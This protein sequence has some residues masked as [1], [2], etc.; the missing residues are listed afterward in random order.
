L[1]G[2]AVERVLEETGVELPDH[3]VVSSPH[4]RVARTVAHGFSAERVASAA[5]QAE[6]GYTGA[7]DLG[8][9]LADALDRAAPGETV[10][11]VAASDGCDTA[12]LEV[13]DAID[14]I[15][16]SAGVR[17]Q[18]A[19]GREV[20]YADYLTWRGI[21]ERESPRRPDPAAPAGPA[22][23]R[24]EGWKFRFA[25]SRC[26]ECQTMH[27]PPQRTCVECGAIDRMC[28]E[29]LADR[30]GT[31][32]TYSVDRLAYSLAPPV[33]D[34]VVDFDG[35]GRRQCQM[36]DVKPDEVAVGDRVELS[37]RRIYTADDVH[38]YFWKARPARIAP[39]DAENAH[40]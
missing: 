15:D 35:G 34:A 31:I 4:R 40:G 25:G 10:L 26:E 37:F 2:E 12:L 22:S 27:V 8:L 36:T 9:G 1:V 20:S 11:L 30:Q 19:G 13:T 33:I 16:R 18:L 7:A 17:A 32:T 38:N 21:L 23:A 14:R 28:E 29:S 3:V 24:N 39:N 6:V 5:V